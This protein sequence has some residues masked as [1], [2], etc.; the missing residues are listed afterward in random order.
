MTPIT[1]EQLL[2]GIDAAAQRFYD[3]HGFK[4]FTKELRTF[5]ADEAEAASGKYVQARTALFAPMRTYELAAGTAK[6]G[7]LV[8]VPAGG[9]GG[10]PRVVRVI[11][12]GRRDD[13]TGE[14]RKA[15][16][17]DSKDRARLEAVLDIPDFS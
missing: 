4:L 1:S 2:D 17:I 16:L 3:K 10:T 15:V 12:I 8:T 14:L 5:I 6:V 9:R 7:D 13:Y 11:A